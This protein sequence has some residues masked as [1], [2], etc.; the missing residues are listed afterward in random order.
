M[1]P[2]YLQKL[3]EQDEKNLVRRLM[4]SDGVD[5]CSN[6]YLGFATDAALKKNI[7]TAIQ[8]VHSGSTGSRLLRG[9]TSWICQLEEELAVF[10]GTEDAVFFPSGYQANLGLLSAVL[11]KNSIAFSDEFNHA[12]IIDG[13]RLSGADKKIFKHNSLED[14]EA[15]F[16][17][18]PIDKR[19]VVVI[20][21]IYSMK[22]D[23]APLKAIYELCLKHKAELIVDE[24]HATGVYQS[25]MS[26][27]L[28]IQSYL[29]ATLHSGGK[30]LGVGGAWVATSAM[31]KDYIVN[32]SRPFIYSTAPS[33]LLTEA[34]RAALAYWQQVGEERAFTAK[35]KARDL[36]A[37]LSKF[38]SEDSLTGDSLIQYLNVQQS[39][40]AIE[41]SGRLHQQSLD[42]RAIR[43]PTVPE[44][45][46]GLRIS[47][48]ADHSPADLRTLVGALRRLVLEC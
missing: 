4:V 22:G 34:L 47:I 43:F 46:A 45:Q 1:N 23:Q 39:A 7:L 18:A 12:S 29:L 21:S 32:F 41:W 28:G 24:T 8:D 17:T 33:P 26:Q 30:A 11:D 9:N 16:K 48:H 37:D 35:E 3:V 2:Y 44:N 6:D 38:M 40:L 20:E 14:L 19:K 25:G 42:I 10:S 15:Q 27:S 13:I 31:V 5:F 36:R